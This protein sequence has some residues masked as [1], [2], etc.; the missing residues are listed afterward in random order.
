MIRFC[1][2]LQLEDCFD[3]AMGNWH[4]VPVLLYQPL[5][6]AC[7]VLTKGDDLSV[8]LG[9]GFIQILVVELVRLCLFGEIAIS[10]SLKAD[11]K[12]VD[13][14]ISSGLERAEGDLT[15]LGVLVQ[16]ELLAVV[17]SQKVT[18]PN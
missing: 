12:L 2:D 4:H 15:M 16:V 18:S 3:A 10:P 8:A 1:R 17:S 11:Q 13:G 6:H 9:D 5:L 14:N 7:E